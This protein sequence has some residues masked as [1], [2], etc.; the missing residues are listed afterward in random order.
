MSF[1]PSSV[2]MS[3]GCMS[4]L[5]LGH[6]LSIPG[7]CLCLRE[8]YLWTCSRWTENLLIL[9]C[10][11]FS[12]RLVD[13]GVHGRSFWESLSSVTE[14]PRAQTRPLKAGVGPPTGRINWCLARV[15]LILQLALL[16]VEVE[17]AGARATPESDNLL[18]AAL[19]VAAGVCIGIRRDEWRGADVGYGAV[20]LAMGVTAILAVLRSGGGGVREWLLGGTALLRWFDPASGPGLLEVSV[21]ATLGVVLLHSDAVAGH[22]AGGT[23]VL[24]ACFG[25]M[26]VFGPKLAPPPVAPGKSAGE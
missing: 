12:Y 8:V 20:M 7:V 18:A 10:C 11:L 16:T 25:P 6:C 13:G 1:L 4:M 2:V 17:A 23:A 22:V 19:L 24:E 3:C 15:V 26:R 5:P 9:G 21:L 14:A